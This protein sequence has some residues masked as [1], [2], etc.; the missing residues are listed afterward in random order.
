MT[1]RALVTEWTVLQ[2]VENSVVMQ[3]KLH[4]HSAGLLTQSRVMKNETDM[5]CQSRYTRLENLEFQM[6][7]LHGN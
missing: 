4:N 1:H 2:S 6:F 3:Q 5:I 7:K